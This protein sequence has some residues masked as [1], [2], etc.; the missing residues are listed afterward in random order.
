MLSSYIY[1]LVDSPLPLTDYLSSVTVKPNGEGS[2]VIWTVT[3]RRKNA[4]DTTPEEESDQ[5]A[6]G[7]LSG[8][9]R[10]GLD[11]LKMM[12]DK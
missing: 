9:Y 1:R 2:E 11:N 6:I 12:L 7:L 8:V 10:G 5:A 3:F 4:A